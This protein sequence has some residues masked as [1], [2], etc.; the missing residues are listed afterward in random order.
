MRRWHSSALLV[1]AITASMASGVAGQEASSTG[2]TCRQAQAFVASRGAATLGTGGRT[3]D[4]FVTDR[5]HCEPTEE[6][7]TAFVPTRDVRGCQIGYRC[8]EPGPSRW[9]G[10]R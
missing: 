3:Y 5:S 2:M 1:A 4:R 6:V 10:G 7:R 8:F 9:R